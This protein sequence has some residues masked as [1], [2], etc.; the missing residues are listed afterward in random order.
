[1]K[2]RSIAIVEDN[3]QLAQTIS[4]SIN[5]S[6]NFSL[7]FIVSNYRDFVA[8]VSEIV[9]DAILMDLQLEDEFSG[10]DCTKWIKK[11]HPHVEILV[12]TVF[13]DSENVFESL[14]FGASGYI[15]KNTPP[16]EI[17]KS[18]DEIFEGGA[19]MSQKIARMVVNS[20]HKK[21]I[22]SPLTEKESQIL[23]LLARGAS[24]KSIAQSQEVAL[25]TVKFHIKNI[26]LK[27]QVSNKEDALDIAR[28]N[29]WLL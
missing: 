26:Y 28:Q 7:A 11:T 18:F 1:M 4:E 20:F 6:D 22:Q 24:Y 5:K 27:L 29:K 13:E 8:N 10:L 21:T 3:L 15:T 9:P 12:F 19:P 16:D 2:R 17:L 14:K 23:E 25:T